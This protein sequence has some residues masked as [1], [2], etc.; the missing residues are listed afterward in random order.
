MLTFQTNK[1]KNLELSLFK[2]VSLKEACL[3]Y[4]PIYVH[5]MKT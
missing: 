1:D 4:F 3:T 5:I 2:R